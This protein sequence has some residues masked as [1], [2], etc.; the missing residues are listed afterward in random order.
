M[1]LF[2]SMQMK[3]ISGMEEAIKEGEDINSPGGYNGIYPLIFAI[4]TANMEIIHTLIRHGAS[5]NIWDEI[6]E[7]TPLML[8]VKKELP[9]VVRLLLRAGADPTLTQSESRTALSIAQQKGFSEIEALLEV[10][11]LEQKPS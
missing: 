2:E 6:N 1:G 11:L 4:A 5:P 8:A 3:D 7:C 9:D 10:A